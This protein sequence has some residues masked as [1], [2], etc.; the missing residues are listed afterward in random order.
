MLFLFKLSIITLSVIKIYFTCT[1]RYIPLSRLHVALDDESYTS[2]CS[3]PSVS[4]CKEIEVTA[5][6]SVYHCKIGDVDAAAKV[7]FTLLHLF[8]SMC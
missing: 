7:K 3:F 2:R 1:F 8:G 6:S 5:S 4:L